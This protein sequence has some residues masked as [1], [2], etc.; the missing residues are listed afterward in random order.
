MKEII[1]PE[2][3]SILSPDLTNGELPNDPEDAAVF[4][5]ANIGPK[6]HDASDIFSLKVVTRKHLANDTGTIWGHGMLVVDRFSWQV[7]E[8]TLQKL[9]LHCYRSTWDEVANQINK[10]L[11]WEF[12]NYTEKGAS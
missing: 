8:S 5:E 1:I 10:H 3:K 2:I 6:N 7:V 4:V 12:D 11:D 9:L